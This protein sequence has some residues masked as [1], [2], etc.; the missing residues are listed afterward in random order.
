MRVVIAG[1]GTGGHINP[2][3]AIAEALTN[4]V[5]GAQVLFVGGG[6]LERKLVPEA[7]W[8]FAQVAARQ[9]PRRLSFRSVWALMVLGIGGMQALYVLGR[10]KPAV[11][12]ATGGYAAA[13]VGAAAAVL[14]I[15]LVVQ[16]QNLIPG[17]TNRILGRWA[18]RVSVAEDAVI[19]YFP[20][21]AV[22]TGVPVRKAALGGDRMQALRRFGLTDDRLT[23]LVLGGS[24]GAQS[25]NTAVIAM[26][27]LLE[28]GPAVQILHQT[29]K[30]HVDWVRA[31]VSEFERSKPTLRYVLVP[32]IE[33]IGDAYA[34]ADLVICRAGF[35]TLSELTANGCPAILVPYPYA[36]GGHQ[37]PNARWLEAA[38]AATVM[39]DRDL[40]G[41]RLAAAVR[42]LA[43][44]RRR[45][46]AMAEA[47]RA[48]G[49]PDAAQAVAELIVESAAVDRRE[50]AHDR[51]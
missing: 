46:R 44:D 24:Q 31:Q 5:P 14:R 12:V 38:G 3:L 17:A 35:G 21:K 26:L 33:A 19:R 16:E 27:P 15:P 34:C 41:E 47:S 4:R 48:L 11:V 43:E 37:E 49:R 29:G 18:R 2:G 40:S 22:A 36:A 8:P 7:G 45:L 1:G 32:Y 28:R 51:A 39:L 10:L 25:L 42:S 30:T 50:G 9:F 13:A 6:G 20:G 23:V